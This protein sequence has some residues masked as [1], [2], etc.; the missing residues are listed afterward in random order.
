M[1]LIVGLGNPGK[2]YKNTPHNIG[3]RVIDALKKTLFP[4]MSWKKRFE[5]GFLRV[6]VEGE[7]VLFFKPFTYMNRSG[8]AV[9]NA[10]AAFSL[11]PESLWIVHDEYDL[12]FGVL[13]V[14]VS[15]S[16]AGHKGVQSIIDALG[17]NR[18]WRFRVGVKP[19]VLPDVMDEYLTSFDIK[20]HL[21]GIDEVIAIQVGKEVLDSL[22][23]GIAK[24]NMS[25][26]LPAGEL[27]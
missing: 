8:L 15:R 17:T 6:E 7:E 18:F 22:R 14:D 23:Q 26:L 11:G 19:E 2:K 12:P 5:G 25:L 3:F 16:S 9:R 13:K 4:R 1:I 10:L 27:S 24:R 20:M 21:R